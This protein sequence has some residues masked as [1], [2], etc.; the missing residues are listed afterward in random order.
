MKKR[1]ESDSI[2]SLE[3]PEKA[4]YG[5]QALRAKQNFAITG[6][7]MNSEFLNN[8]ALIKKAAAITNYKAGLLDYDKAKAICSAAEEVIKGYFKDDFIVDAVQGGAGTSANMNMN[9]VIANRAN[10]LLGGKLGYYDKIHPNDHVNMAQSTNDVIPT[11]GKM[12]VIRLMQPL[13]DELRRLESTL[14]EKAL[15]FRYVIKMGRTQLQ[16]AVPMTLGESFGGYASMIDRC[17]SRLENSCLEMHTINIGATAIGS[18]INA[19][20]YYERNIAKI[21]SKEF[22]HHLTK[23]ADLFDATENLDSFEEISG[24]L[25]ACAVSLSKM[26]NDLRLLSSGPRCGLHEI[27][28]PAKQNG[29]SIMPGKVNP[30]I[31]EVVTQAAFLVIGHDTTIAM[32]AEAGQLELN[33]F[34]PVVFYQL[35]E[36]ITVLTHAVTTL[37]DNC[38]KGITANS[39][40]CEELE[41]GSVGIATALSPI[42]GYQKSASIAKQALHEEKTIREIVLEQKLMDPEKLDMVLDPMSMVGMIRSA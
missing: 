28:L 27:N 22:G 11:A 26:C 39:D 6:N 12:T 25:K 18:G 13:T 38:I 4:Y 14:Y 5:V 10:E 24:A 17:C 16:D 42:L 31:P 35:F 19:S 9:E 15:Q 1:I 3:V 40:H 34:E 32:A 29:S 21:L 8:L 30:V 36:S 20:D 33:A 37:I 2:G 41:E 7:M 23:A